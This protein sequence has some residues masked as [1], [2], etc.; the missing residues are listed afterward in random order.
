MIAIAPIQESPCIK[1]KHQEVFLEMLPRI[2]SRARQAFG[3][4]GSEMK[5]E[6]IQEVVANAFCA[7]MSLVRR[8]KSEIAYATPLTNYAIRQVLGGRQVG[9]KLNVNDV[10]SPYA[11]AACRFVVARLDQFD[12][13]QGDWREVLVEDRRATPADIATARIDVAEWLRTLP[14]RHRQIAETLAMG[15][16]TSEVASKFKLS[17]ARISQLRVQLRRSW[18]QFQVGACGCRG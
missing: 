14:A 6:L 9:A 1:Q 16:T 2:R 11:Q 18:E 4:L 17:P 12:N 10:T 15:E 5:D 7:F 3:W 8:G 13:D